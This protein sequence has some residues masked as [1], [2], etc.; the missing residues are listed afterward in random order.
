MSPKRQEPHRRHFSIVTETYP[1][2]IN[3]VALTL[4]H[5][6]EGLRQRGHQVSLV[7][8][9]QLADS[10]HPI[11][12][13][14]VTLVS[15]LPLPGYKSLRM[16]LPAADVLRRRWVQPP[17]VVYV[18]TQ[19]PLGW[20]AVGA[21]RQ[22]RIPVFS[23]FHTNFDNYAQHYYG[24]RLRSLI[25]WYLKHFHN[26]TAGTIVPSV[27]LRDRLRAIG[28][29]NISVLGRGVD[30]RL[31]TP[32]R[33]SADLRRAWRAGKNAMVALYVG[34]IA[35]EKNLGLAID[36]YR[37][38]QR[39]DSGMKFA[40]VG[41][42]PL[43]ATLQ[44]KHPDLIFCGVKTGDRLAAHYASADIFL[45]PSESETFGNVTVE[46]MASGL[47]VVAYDYAA[48]RAHIKDGETGMLAS[49]GDA[50]AFIKAATKLA[51]RRQSR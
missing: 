10:V 50:Q 17:D 5:L 44:K 34:R 36:A 31:F 22:L 28:L 4:S 13:A 11:S 41:D 15:G 26:L 51:L 1:P 18:A 37:A 9:R 6:V 8:P 42:G 19:G 27:D 47:A 3:G 38:M 23:G 32:A 21:A 33:R 20:S 12:D 48:A 45:F 30:G 35:A 29:K 25:L 40:L 24:S 16:G 43:R 14:S 49:Y 46:A 7:R 39:I 2:E